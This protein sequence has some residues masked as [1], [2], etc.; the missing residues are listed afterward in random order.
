MKN[1][2]RC[3]DCLWIGDNDDLLSADNPFDEGSILGCPKCLYPIGVSM[4]T[5]CDVPGCGE[6]AG[7]G[8]PTSEGYRWTCGRHRPT[9]GVV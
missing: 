6:I 8:T 3:T 9:E 2:I 7:C 5:L 1:K 4:E